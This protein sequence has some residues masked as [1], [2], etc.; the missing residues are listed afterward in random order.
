MKDRETL[1]Y[2]LDFSVSLNCSKVYLKNKQK[3]LMYGINT[4]KDT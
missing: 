3:T 4:Q 2:L 1:C